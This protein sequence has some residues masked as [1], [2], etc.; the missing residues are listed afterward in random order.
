MPSKS[1][2]VKNEKQYEK[3]K[4]K[5]MSPREARRLRGRN[6]LGRR[7]RPH[8]NHS[9]PGAVHINAD[10]TTSTRFGEPAS[11]LNRTGNLLPSSG[12]AGFSSTGHL[13]AR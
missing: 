10:G 2:N 5:G 8:C 6:E 9:A 3:L 12:S 4:E 1:A 11:H 13:A 7:F